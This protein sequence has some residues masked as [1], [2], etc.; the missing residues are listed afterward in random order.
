MRFASG[1]CLFGIR[2]L[3]GGLPHQAD[4]DRQDADQQ[5]DDSGQNP[6]RAPALGSHGLSLP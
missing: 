6:R 2:H 5:K 3:L 1:R 4:T